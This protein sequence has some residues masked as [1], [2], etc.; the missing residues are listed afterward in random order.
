MYEKLL[1]KAGLKITGPRQ[2][3]LS[4][5]HDKAKRHWSAE[6]MH[7][8]LLEQGEDVG[9]ATVYRVLTQFEMCGLVKRHF[10][11]NDV[12]VVELNESEH[13]DHLVCVECGAVEEFLD[14][15]IEQHQ[16]K[17]ADRFNFKMTDHRLIIY[18]DCAKCHK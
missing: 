12:S 8:V 15:V 14:D 9:L 17:I 2:K 4:L 18:G 1:R 16:K 11:E 3:I 6:S 5:L 13:H 7:Q 10:F